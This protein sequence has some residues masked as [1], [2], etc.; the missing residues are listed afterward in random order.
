MYI[1]MEPLRM[2]EMYCWTREV[3]RSA[4]TQ[5]SPS[6][7]DSRTVFLIV[8]MILVLEFIFLNLS[9]NNIPSNNLTSPPFACLVSSVN[10]F[11]SDRQV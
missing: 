4:M 2:T 8:L 10:G 6:R 11:D 3:G 5:V 1:P 7:R 9:L